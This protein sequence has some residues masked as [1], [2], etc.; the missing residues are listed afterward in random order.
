MK[1]LPDYLQLDLDIVIVGINPSVYSVQNGH[2]YAGPRN[3]F[4][5]SA[6]EAR[7]FP[8]PLG[9]KTDARVLEF[10]IGLT[11]VVK[12]PSAMANELQAAD[13]QRWVPVVRAKIEKYKPRIVCFHGVSGFRGY[14]R[15]GEGVS[16]RPKSGPQ[17][18]RLGSSRVFLI[19]SSS[20]AN[21]RWCSDQEL[22]DW[23]RELRSLRDA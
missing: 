18:W 2:Y 4:W 15:H 9:P 16:L 3:R 17:D 20:P 21:R 6:N 7:L 8:E 14:L 23:F 5:Q 10:G 19:P 13:Y 12:R 11:D 1:T 22:V